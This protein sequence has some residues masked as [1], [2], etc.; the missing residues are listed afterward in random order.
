MRSYKGKTLNKADKRLIGQCLDCGAHIRVEDEG[1]V[2]L[3]LVVKNEGGKI[4]VLPMSLVR[5][6]IESTTTEDERANWQRV[7]FTG[8]SAR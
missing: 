7:A 5:G 4:R 2:W 3:C 8:I 6:T 1:E